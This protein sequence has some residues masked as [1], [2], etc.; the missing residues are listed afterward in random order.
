MTGLAQLQTLAGPKL[1]AGV[2][3]LVEQQMGDALAKALVVGVR[4]R[5]AGRVVNQLSQYQMV[6]HDRSASA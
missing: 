1:A 6:P 3:Q 2:A 4:N 5:L